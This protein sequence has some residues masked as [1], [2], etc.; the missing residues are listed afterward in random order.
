LNKILYNRIN[1]LLA[2]LLLTACASEGPAVR[3]TDAEG[4][5]SARARNSLAAN[6]PEGLIRVGEG[7]ERSGNLQGAMNIYGQAMAADPALIEAQVSY[8]RVLIRMGGAERGTAMLTALLADHPEN[9]QVRAGL[10]KAHILKGEFKAAELFM[11][12]LLDRPETSAQYLNLGGMIAQ[13]GGKPVYARALF[14]RALDKSVG[15]PAVL[16]NMALSFALDEDYASAVAL[17]Q[18]A[19]DRPSGLISGKVVLATIYALS[20]QLEAAM[21]L[22]RDSMELGKANERKVFYQLL[23]RLTA[24][25]RAVAVMFDQVPKDAVDR[26]T[27]NAA[28]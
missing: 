28:K 10:S 15:D 24:H 1:R 14:G 8:A 26:L 22:A 9:D 12:P 6:N 11:Q 16:E 3:T 23:P 27:G 13:V 5:V 7:F 21:L 4:P 25:E 17:I 19:M 20:G 18:T 2:L